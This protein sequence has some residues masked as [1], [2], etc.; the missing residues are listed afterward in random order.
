[1]LRMQKDTVL[2]AYSTTQMRQIRPEHQK[3]QL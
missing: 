1:M 3:Y 2:V